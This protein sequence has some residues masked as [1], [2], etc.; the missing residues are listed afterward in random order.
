M[1]TYDPDGDDLI[2]ENEFKGFVKDIWDDCD[3][4]CAN[5]YWKAMNA[6]DKTYKGVSAED[7][8]D[9]YYLIDDKATP[10]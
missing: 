10:K 2:Q 8:L 3:E 6:Y 1:K 4:E 9:C 5:K 7:F